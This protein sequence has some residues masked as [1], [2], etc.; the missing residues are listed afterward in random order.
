MQRLTR[1]SLSIMSSASAATAAAGECRCEDAC[2]P[3]NS[4][5]QSA[6]IPGGPGAAAQ[7]AAA[8]AAHDPGGSGSGSDDSSSGPAAPAADWR[9]SP[10]VN[11]AA[12]ADYKPSLSSKEM[13]RAISSIG[14][15][16]RMRRVA[17][18]LLAGMPVSVAFLG[19]SLTV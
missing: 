12:V 13:D 2:G 6:A 18:K 16:S 17:A 11:Q 10:H 1:A 4:T 8:E 15:T 7:A 14:D 3:A 9:R 5:A 19:G